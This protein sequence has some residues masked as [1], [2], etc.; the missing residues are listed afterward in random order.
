MASVP[1][2]RYASKQ[3]PPSASGQGSFCAVNTA[4]CPRDPSG[5]RLF[6]IR[7][8]ITPFLLRHL[9]TLS[10]TTPNAAAMS[11]TAAPDT[12]PT[13]QTPAAQPNPELVI[14]A[15]S[16]DSETDSALG[17]DAYASCL[18]HARAIT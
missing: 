13:E 10:P 12:P 2:A 15:D 14:E 6:A 18:L 9:C 7:W 16:H 3:D 17:D 5:S 4:I 11:S 1:L 8:L